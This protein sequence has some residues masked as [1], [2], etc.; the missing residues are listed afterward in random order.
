M[1]FVQKIFATFLVLGILGVMGSFALYF[2][3]RHSVPFTKD[4][5]YGEPADSFARMIQDQVKSK[6]WT[7]VGAIKWSI[8]NREYL[9]DLQR[10]LVRLKWE[11]NRILFDVKRQ[12]EVVYIDNKK[13]EGDPAKK[14]IDE[15]YTTWQ[16]DL[17]ILDPMHTFF[18]Q[19]VIRYLVHAGQKK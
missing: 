2:T 7:Y 9:W 17:F 16:R 5:M 11:K 15:A 4:A 10:G 19:G 18:N 6:S 1:K 12:R 8:F 14:M 3:A 13:I